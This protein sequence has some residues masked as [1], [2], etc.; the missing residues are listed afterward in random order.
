MMS[1]ERGMLGNIGVSGNVEENSLR[2]K[3]ERE[4]GEELWKGD[5]EEGATCGM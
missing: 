4:W 3:W 5:L 2:V 1:N